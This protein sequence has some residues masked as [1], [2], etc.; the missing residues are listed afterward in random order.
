MFNAIS[1]G[2][3]EAKSFIL[4]LP[5][6]K[7]KHFIQGQRIQQIFKLM[8]KQLSLDKKA[9]EVDLKFKLIKLYQAVKLLEAVECCLKWRMQRQIQ[10]Q[11]NMLGTAARWDPKSRIDIEN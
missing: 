11:E 10:R 2:S 5:G 8:S 6:L 9:S 1:C 3:T 4:Q 7:F